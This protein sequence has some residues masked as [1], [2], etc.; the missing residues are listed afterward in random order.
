[1]KG[2]NKKLFKR[3]AKFIE[4]EETENLHEG[5]TV[6]YIPV[7]VGMSNDDKHIGII[8]SSTREI[9]R[10]YNRIIDEEIIEEIRRGRNK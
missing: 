5:E 1:M 6:V 7:T 9:I 10:M 4:S 2:L 8:K 3:V